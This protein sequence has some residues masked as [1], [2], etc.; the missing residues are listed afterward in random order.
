MRGLP[1]S[2]LQNHLKSIKARIAWIL[3]IAFL[4]F[5]ALDTAVEKYIIFPGF[6]ALEEEDAQRD[7]ERCVQAIE[8]EIDHLDHLCHDYAAWNETYEFVKTPYESYIEGNLIP[9]TFEGNRLDM[10][11]LCNREGRVVWGRFYD[12]E[13][14]TFVRLA[15]FPHEQ[16]PKNHPLIAYETKNLPLNEVRAAGIYP[17]VN[18]PMLISSRPVLTSNNEGPIRGSVMM[19][20]FLTQDEVAAIAEQTRVNFSVK[21]VPPDL[22]AAAA[23]GKIQRRSMPDLLQISKVLPDLTGKPVLEITANLPRR[24]AQRGRTTIR[25]AMLSNLFAG[26]ELILLLLLVLQKTVIRPLIRLKDHTLSVG[27]TGDLTARLFDDPHFRRKDEIGALAREFDRMLDQLNEMREELSEQFYLYGMAEMAAGLLHQVSNQLN[28]MTGQVDFLKAAIDH[29][30]AERLAL[31]RIELM[32]EETP[33]ERREALMDFIL[34]ANESL[35]E[36]TRNAK[37]ILQDMRTRILEIEIS[38]QKHR[39]WIYSGRVSAPVALAE[40]VDGGLSKLKASVLQ[41]VEICIAPDLRQYLIK[42]ERLSFIQIFNTLFQNAA[43]EKPSA[44][45]EKPSLRIDA[46]PDQK[47]GEEMIRIRIQRDGGLPSDIDVD[48]IFERGYKEGRSLSGIS[49]HWCAI[50]IASM[51]GR[52]KAR[53]DAEAFCFCLWLPA[54]AAP[55]DQPEKEGP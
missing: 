25:Y 31:A 33:S 13:L 19:G 15:G 22:S 42:G 16:F 44:G 29:M 3:F 51:G 39:G 23:S 50:M 32:Q 28:S 36:F 14:E 34:A 9:T 41:E 53:S 43:Q 20:R 12:F 2:V 37:G 11:Y 8:S 47:G 10:I 38:L 5:V 21:P 7:M 17:T 4:F 35:V 26:A 54:G 49:L 27:R 52:I 18:G 30:P 24:I 48:R 6:L 1:N 40:A 45:G 46:K 55:A